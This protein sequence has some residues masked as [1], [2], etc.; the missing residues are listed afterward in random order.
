MGKMGTIFLER[1]L[2]TG[3]GVMVLKSKRADL[4]W[5]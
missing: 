3:H 2:V 4:G 1:P 5:V